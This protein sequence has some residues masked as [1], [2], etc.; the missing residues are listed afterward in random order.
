MARSAYPE[1]LALVRRMLA[2]DEEAFE[3]FSRDTFSGIYRFALSRLGQDED[4]AREIAQATVV[5]AIESLDRY[6][7][8]AALM[9]WLCGICRFQI[10]GHLRRQGRDPV[11]ARLEDETP[12]LRTALNVLAG[13][14]DGPEDDLQNKEVVRLVHEALDHLPRRYSDALEWKYLEDLPVAEIGER[15]GVGMKAAESVLSRAR[16]A[17]RKAFRSCGLV[18]KGNE[19]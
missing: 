11:Q 1:D 2:G 18:A 17:F 14:E 8:D 10:T 12:A 9:S 15:L 19:S 3:Q 4:L 7:G 13:Q 5:A 6:R 16:E